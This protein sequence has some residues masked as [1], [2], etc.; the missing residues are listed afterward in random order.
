[1]LK[2]PFAI[3]YDPAVRGHLAFIER[4]HH[5]FIR[6]AI[7]EQLS[8]EPGVTTRSRKPLRRSN[9]LVLERAW[10]LRCGPDNRFRVFYRLDEEA[11]EV[12]VVAIG[13][14]EGSRL[15]V[16]GEETSP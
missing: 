3:R 11:R 13:I 16:G 10:E 9:R 6:A 14:K 12:L 7:K 1:M 5:S 15:F 2:L 4:N 8:H